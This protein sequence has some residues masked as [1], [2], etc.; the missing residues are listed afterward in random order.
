MH[1]VFWNKFAY[2]LERDSKY[3]LLLHVHT[4]KI[5][6]VFTQIN[7][8][9]YKM[10]HPIKQTSVAHVSLQ[11]YGAHVLSKYKYSQSFTTPNSACYVYI[12]YFGQHLQKWHVHR[13]SEIGPHLDR[14][15][16]SYI[17]IVLV[18]E[19]W[20]AGSGD[21]LPG[22][23]K[24]LAWCQPLTGGH[25]CKQKTHQSYQGPHV[26]YIYKTPYPYTYIR[27]PLFHI[28]QKG[29]RGHLGRWAYIAGVAFF[30]LLQLW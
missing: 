29:D 15:Q 22:S 3:C 25:Y 13:W 14:C 17:W 18:G 19:H 16:I 2:N 4:F 7:R 11:L 20:V 8:P 12:S 10:W 5:K 1:V 30:C 6:L 27:K 24:G 28:N 23:G 26:Q 9:L 21:S